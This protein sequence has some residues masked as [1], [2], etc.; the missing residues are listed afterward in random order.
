[1]RSLISLLQLG[2]YVL[3]CERHDLHRI[4]NGK[5]SIFG[6]RQSPVMLRTGRKRWKLC[7]QYKLCP[8]WSMAI[9][10]DTPR[11]GEGNKSSRKTAHLRTAGWEMCARGFFSA[12]RAVQGRMKTSQR[13]EG[14]APCQPKSLRRKRNKCCGHWALSQHV[15]IQQPTERGPG[16]RMECI[17]GSRILLSLPGWF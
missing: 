12:Q 14:E 9:P 4:M 2:P 3:E 7:F 1:M 13:Q 6:E 8:W 10:E 16:C 17:L 11:V 15:H 5:S